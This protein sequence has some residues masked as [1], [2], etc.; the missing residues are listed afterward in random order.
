MLQLGYLQQMQQVQAKQTLAWHSCHADPEIADKYDTLMFK[1][2]SK[3][4]TLPCVARSIWLCTGA[5]ILYTCTC[6]IITSVKGLA[7][8]LQCNTC[9]MWLI[10]LVPLT[11]AHWQAGCLCWKMGC[12]C[13]EL[14][15]RVC[16]LDQSTMT[17]WQFVLE[18]GL[19]RL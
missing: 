8:Q 6:S 5:T 9:S 13:S 2:A 16:S 17:G 1:Q 18:N 12:A 3:P 10:E 19:I 4:F 7:Q 14:A 15:A 11:R